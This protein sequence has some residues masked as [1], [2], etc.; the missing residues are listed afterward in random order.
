MMNLGA[1]FLIRVVLLLNISQ[2]RRS[3]V[4][5]EKLMEG[6]RRSAMRDFDSLV[7]ATS[8]EALAYP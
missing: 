4:P 1:T 7:M 5:R 2:I 3:L 8:A 6:I